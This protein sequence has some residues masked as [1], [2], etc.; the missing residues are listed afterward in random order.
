[1]KLEK[2]LSQVNQFEKNTFLKILDQLI[3]NTKTPPRNKAVIE[4]IL[5]ES[6][7]GIR[8]VDDKVIARIFNLLEDEYLTFLNS[9]FL[10]TNS[11][12]DIL[13]D[14]VNRDG[15][16]IMMHDWFAR[17]YENELKHIVKKKTQLQKELKEE[18]S[19]L[20]P[21]RKRDYSIY[22][23]C[24][25]TAYTNDLTHNREAR[26][27]GDELSILIKLAEGLDLSQE[28]VKLI[29][30]IVIPP[31][32]LSTDEAIAELKNLG[33][34]FYSK[35]YNSVYVPDEIVRVLRILRGKKVADKFY[36][37]VLKLLR[38]PQINLVCRKHGINWK[39]SFDE[40]VKSIINE[41]IPFDKLLSEDIYKEGTS[42]T[43]RKAFLNDLCDKGLG[44]SPRL[45]G[46]TLEEKISNLIDYFDQVE[47]DERV[48]ISIDGYEKL[49]RELSE[50]IPTLNKRVKN[51]FE[52][53]DEDVMKSELLLD[54]N[55]KPRDILE[56]CSEK[57]LKKFSEGKAVKKRGNLISNILEAYKDTENILIENYE[58]IAY[59]DQ[60]TLKENGIAMKEADLGLKFEDLTK[61]IFEELGFNVDEDLKKQ[62]NTSKDK[63]DVLVNL[64]NQDL[65]LIECKTSKERG[66]N[67][68]SSVSRQLK[69]YM[70]LARKNG[71]KVVKSLLIA[72]EFSD[73]FINECELE[74]ELNLSLIK[75]GSLV[76][77][78]DGF[79]GSKKHS[80]FPYKLLMRD[81]LISEDRILKAIEK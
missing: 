22:L 6:D 24:V 74:Y 13:I 36:R 30:Y 5:S 49:L 43:D 7:K 52:L 33:I 54:Y 42:L 50:A 18:K 16:C 59:R 76:R 14:I 79:K 68:F 1:M 26:I 31:Q 35:K 81:V 44:I 72:P 57:E 60:N 40:K 55:I 56:L 80:Q 8:G 4:N 46:T 38:E 51:E 2:V 37:R 32:K 48:G 15:N 41:G 53:Q 29:N 10:D 62:L 64:G 9:E 70:D 11:Q 61:T 17:L 69:A 73:E 3:E 47:R 66:Y 63:M 25:H 78:L 21:L 75:A 58:A 12:A 45:K 71:Y 28:E 39:D 77:I 20:E 27:T 67:K 65:I 34:A 23:D 19:S